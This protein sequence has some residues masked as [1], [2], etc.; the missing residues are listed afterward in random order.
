MIWIW[1]AQTISNP[2]NKPTPTLPLEISVRWQPTSRSNYAISAGFRVRIIN[3]TSNGNVKLPRLDSQV[4][5]SAVLHNEMGPQIVMLLHVLSSTVFVV[6]CVLWSVFMVYLFWAML[7]YRLLI[8]L[9]SYIVIDIIIH[10][11]L[12]MN[13]SLFFTPG[14]WLVSPKL[15]APTACR[16]TWLRG[17]VLGI[18]LTSPNGD[19]PSVVF[20]YEPRLFCVFGLSAQRD[21]SLS[22]SENMMAPGSLLVEGLKDVKLTARYRFA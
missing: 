4:T 10:L 13:V 5:S 14:K 6:W 3:M 2:L 8:L 19:F 1:K 12:R 21:D 7:F 18:W 9:G 22:T 17:P 15:G 20:C 11:L 16:E